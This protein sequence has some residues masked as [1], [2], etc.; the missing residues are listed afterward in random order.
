MQFGSQDFWLTQCQ[1]TLAYSKALQYRAEKAQLLIP[2][3]PY[4]LAES[5]LELWQMMEPLIMFTDE[6]VLDH[7][8]P[9]NWVKITPSR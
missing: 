9:S 7:V 3:E 4:Q 1:K 5:M 2:S 6:E 8:P